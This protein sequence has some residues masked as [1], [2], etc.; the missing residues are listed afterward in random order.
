MHHQRLTLSTLTAFSF[1]ASAGFATAALPTMDMAISKFLGTT[2]QEEIMQNRIV[3]YAGAH[4]GGVHVDTS[5]NPPRIYMFDSMNNRILGFKGWQPVTLPNGPWPAADIVIGQPAMWDTGAANGNNIKYLPPGAATLALV[6]FPFVSSTAESPRS[7][8][9][10]TDSA[11]NFYLVD[12]C[13]NRVLKYL[14]PFETDQIA[15]Q[16][17]GQNTFTN[18]SPDN[19]ITPP[20]TSAG[21]LSTQWGGGGS[22]YSAGVDVDA[23]GNIW[24]ADSNNNRVLCF[25]N[26][27]KTATVV[28][29]QATFTSSS[30][31]TALNQMNKPTG[32]RVHPAT[33]EVF[34][35]DGEGNPRVMVFKPP[36]TSGKAAQ[37]IFGTNQLS[38][39]RGFCLDPFDTNIAWVASG[40]QQRIVKFNHFTGQALDCIGQVSL[41][42][43][44]DVGRYVRPDGTV[45]N[46]NQPDGSIS[47]DAQ[48][49]L[50]FTCFSGKSRIIRIPL[51][52]TRNA[53]GIVWSNG[54]MLK[55]GMNET[56]GRTVQDNYGMA[57]WKNQLYVHDR[58]R[59][60]V[61]TNYHTAVN[62]QS[63]DFVIG[64]SALD[65]NEQYP[66]GG[67]T[68]EGRWI[69]ML[70]ANEGSNVLFVT[71]DWKTYM[72][73]LPITNGGLHYAAFKTIDGGSGITYKWADDN[74]PCGQLGIGSVCYDPASNVLWVA[75]GARVLR[76]RNIFDD[77]P[78][79]DLVLGQTNKTGL[80]RNKGKFIPVGGTI[81]PNTAA[82][83]VFCK[84]SLTADRTTSGGADGPGTP[85]T[86]AFNSANAM[87]LTED[88]YSG[89]Q[90]RHL[91]FYPTPQQTNVVNPQPTQ[92]INTYL[93][94]PAAC[95]FDGPMFVLQDHTWSRL[96]FHMP[97]AIAPLVFVTNTIVTVT[98]TSTAL[99]GTNANLAGTMQWSNER[100]G[101]GA[102]PAT[103][104]WQ[105]T[106][107]PLQ[108]GANLLTVSGT[109]TGG[110]VGSDAI[111]ILRAFLR[112]E[113]TPAISITNAP[114]TLPSGVTTCALGGGAN[115]HAVGYLRWL[116]NRGGSGSAP[117]TSAWV[118]T[119][120]PLSGGA[121]LISVS[122]TNVFGS[123]A[124]ASITMTR[125]PSPGEG[126]P[127]IDVT[128]PDATV[129]ESITVYSIN[130]TN[131]QNVV[132]SMWWA[133]SLGG[134][135][136]LAA[137]TPWTIPNVLLQ[138][139][140]NVITVF[141]SNMYGDGAAASVRIARDTVIT[142]TNWQTLAVTNGMGYAGAGAG[143][144]MNECS[145]LVK[146]YD[147]DGYV[148]L[149]AFASDGNPRTQSIWRVRASTV[150][151]MATDA[152]QLAI[153]GIPSNGGG[154]ESGQ[155]WVK[156]SNV[157]YSSLWCQFGIPNGGP[158]YWS[159]YGFY[160]TNAAGA[161]SMALEHAA[162]PL[163]DRA[164]GDDYSGAARNIGGIYLWTNIG[165][166]T[167]ICTDRSKNGMDAQV[168]R[169]NGFNNLATLSEKETEG[170]D[171]VYASCIL[172]T[173]QNGRAL[174][175][176][177]YATSGQNWIWCATNLFAGAAN[178]QSASRCYQ[179][180]GSMT[181]DAI[182]D[183][184]LLTHPNFY[185]NTLLAASVW[186]GSRKIHLYNLERPDLAPLDITPATGLGQWRNTL[187]A[188][189]GYLFMNYDAGSEAPGLLRLSL[190]DYDLKPLG[191]P[192]P[193]VLLALLAP[194]LLRVRACRIFA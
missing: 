21:T 3:P 194:A 44:L 82:D 58:Y 25:T 94:Q 11:G 76:I 105:V 63:A 40:N 110:M 16:V 149:Q 37:R 191:V 176:D 183:L 55:E 174:F 67:S 68:F 193:G 138:L 34:V 189:D 192:E 22:T 15:D 143:L 190:I 38:W 177:A 175:L 23:A 180:P 79:V 60:L 120:I 30:G 116:N 172:D 148:Y 187:A 88:T 92:I 20:P 57:R 153:G 170:I 100:G 147:H 41:T 45:A 113:G 130:G 91:F 134:G 140:D 132:G 10:A 56:S 75:A 111:T 159:W 78:L 184:A 69:G 66:A 125:A 122:A 106:G 42:E 87:V 32:V 181:S 157:F 17:W 109:N 9:M 182:V 59:M 156:Y 70:D 144:R 131:N 129:D 2:R 108:F 123:N 145:T 4:V 65:K 62:F 185:G 43:I 49:N 139:G 186:T 29:G 133:N 167:A 47:I 127:Y 102:F 164:T 118:I 50:Y 72:F 52:I 152:W 64:Q 114:Q 142:S 46:F 150:S 89:A 86:L 165:M 35:L 83:A 36:F 115:Q 155:T 90:G 151:S 93:G 103:S 158:W 107:I 126:A 104:P 161:P 96:L 71:T 95:F 169:W 128:T 162:T 179:I 188:H 173:K 135:G 136:T 146:N 7:G 61:W 39:A 137:V 166:L 171:S 53:Q 6:P 168:R 160:T 31:G 51:P 97:R 117:A 24:V 77:F 13:N 112:G 101:A 5:Q 81:F 98:S 33:K 26:G 84:L 28:L 141:G 12:L 119:G 73:R 18:R 74:T 19:T 1:A 121:N 154:G 99:G 163:I 8:M 124:V 54:E 80:L 48:S 14:D 178:I 27:A 85:I